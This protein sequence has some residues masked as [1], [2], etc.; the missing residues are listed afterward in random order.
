MNKL[1]IGG[2]LVLAI[3]FSNSVLAQKTINEDEQSWFAIINTTRLSNRWGI[4]FDAHMRLKDDF[5]Q[6]PSLAIVRGGPTYFVNNDLRLTAAYAFI[7]VFPESAHPEISRPEHR[8]WQQVQWLSHIQKAR[9]MQWVRLEQRFRRN[10]SDQGLLDE[11]YQFNWRMRFN[12]LLTVPLGKDAFRPGGLQAIVNNE[13]MVN[14]GKNIRFNYF[15]QNR[16][17]VG[18]GLQTAP[19]SQL[20][21]GYLN[22]FVQSPAG[23]RF[24][25]IHALRMFYTHNFDFRKKTSS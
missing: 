9:W 12:G 5:V 19:A 13:L 16:F 8:L 22:V 6:K 3:F 2:A 17:F 7:N 11:G 21:L 10:L 1:I 25:N 23:D 20:Q 24:T 14:F 18:L 4:W 15:D